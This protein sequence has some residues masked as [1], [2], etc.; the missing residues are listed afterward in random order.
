LRTY[1]NLRD[2]WFVL[3][4]V[5]DPSVFGPQ[6]W[7]HSVRFEGEL[8]GELEGVLP[9]ALAS[10]APKRRN[11]FLAGRRCATEALRSAGVEA[12]VPPGPDRGPIWPRGWVGAI[13]HTGTFASAVVGS[14]DKL[15]GLG[16]DSEPLL[17]EAAAESVRTRALVGQE[18][19]FATNLE[20]LTVIFSAK[21]SLYK[22]LRPRVGRFFGFTAAEIVELGHGRWVAELREDLG[23]DL[24][25]IE[26]H[27]V[28]GEDLIH[29]GV[30][31][32]R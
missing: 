17:T 24:A 12:S 22:C 10:A 4:R 3:F 20:L 18:I 11:Q 16:L 7:Q 31:W 9:P 1:R 5:K 26:G 28:L 2:D 29:T 14:A 25:R 32:L 21:E 15:L 19:R 6:V 13:T 27:Y 30:S 8:Q 23:I